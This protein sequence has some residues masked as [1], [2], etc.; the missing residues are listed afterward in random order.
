M[1]LIKQWK[2]HFFDKSISYLRKS[3]C[4]AVILLSWITHSMS[5]LS[6][7]VSADTLTILQHD[8]SSLKV[9][10]TFCYSANSLQLLHILPPV[11]NAHE[12]AFTNLIMASTS[13]LAHCY[14][15][16]DMFTWLVL[17]VYG[18]RQTAQRMVLPT[19]I[20]NSPDT[21]LSV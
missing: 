16:A 8:P 19:M 3:I 17:P 11:G 2:Q 7:A 1:N 9:N 14:N 18:R 12:P 20:M 6:S 13:N 5:L 15:E 10:A 21:I 4:T